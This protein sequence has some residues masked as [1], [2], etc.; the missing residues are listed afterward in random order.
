MDTP[1]K[2]PRVTL[3]DAHAL[4]TAHGDSEATDAVLDAMAGSE[5]ELCK[6][7][8]GFARM[9]A[10]FIAKAEGKPEEEILQLFGRRLAARE[11]EDGP[12]PD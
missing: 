3:E 6:V 7:V 11:L 4:I 10:R 9:F 2:P 8:A 12:D 1:Q 5:R